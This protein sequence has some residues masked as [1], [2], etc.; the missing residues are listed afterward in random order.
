MKK[1]FTLFVLVIL[2]HVAF[3]QTP[4]VISYGAQNKNLI[5]EKAIL[6]Q[7]GNTIMLGRLNG[8]GGDFPFISCFDASHV[9]K[10]SFNLNVTGFNASAIADAGNNEFIGT[11]SSGV[12]A[13]IIKFNIAGNL[14]WKKRFS[15]LSD[16]ESILVDASGNIY[17]AG[18]FLEHLHLIKLQPN[19]T[20]AWT[21]KYNFGTN[22]AFGRGLVMSSDNHIMMM[23]STTY[24]NNTNGNKISFLK[25]DPSGTTIWKKTYSTNTS[26]VG[27]GL[28]RSPKTNRYM[29]A[30]YKGN[31][32][33]I[34]TLDGFT[35][36]LDS[37]GNYINNMV[38]G[39]IWWDNHF[40]VTAM[41]EGGFATCGFSKPVEN[42]GGNALFV[43]YTDNND[44]VL[45]RTYGASSGQGTTFQDLK[46]IQNKGLIAFG[47]GSTFSYWNNGLEFESLRLTDN[48]DVNC[49]RYNQA[50]AKSSLTISETTAVVTESN[51]TLNFTEEISKIDQQ[52]NA[53]DVCLQLPL[54]NQNFVLPLESKIY[55][56]PSYG[57]FNIHIDHDRIQ[58]IKIWNLT[59]QTVRE[60]KGN[61]LQVQRIETN[62]LPAGTYFVQIST[63]EGKMGMNKLVIE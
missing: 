43:K 1:L 31:L 12:E 37:N 49:H 59:G 55:P 45:T 51:A 10:F 2:A 39:Y 61:Q 23:A 54:S 22:Y 50:I 48:L 46:Y 47:G 34:N 11:Y 29:M 57:F 18:G 62:N 26:I 32:N 20:I 3:S 15:G 35:M 14:I 4:S 52:I 58:N 27:N 13:I 53:S 30:G 7:Q 5:G 36:L 38:L 19:G 8:T 63:I 60:I 56:N 16:L 24:V 28:A 25:I 6:D 41:P 40:A 42:C 9:Q 21:K 17:T 44:T 33:S